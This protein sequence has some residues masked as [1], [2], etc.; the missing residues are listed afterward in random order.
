LAG[1]EEAVFAC[2][3]R[4]EGGLEDLLALA[5]AFSPSVE[6][7]DQQTVVFSI[8]GLG[9][10]IGGPDQIASEVARRGAEAG[11]TANLAIAADPDTAI[12]TARCLPGVH[13][14]PPGKEAFWLGRIP[15]SRVPMPEELHETLTRWGLR[16]LED[17]AALPPIGLAERLGE[18]GVRLYRTAT[19]AHTRPLK[20]APPEASYGENLELEDPV[21]NL[22]PLLFLI[23]RILNELCRRLAAQFQAANRVTTELTLEDGATHRRILE[24]PAPLADARQLL[25]LIQLDLEAHPP[26]AAVTAV[27][28]HLQPVRPRS[29]QNDLFLPP[30]PAP[31][32]LQLTL[33]RLEGIAG[34]GNVGSPEVLDTHRPDAVVMR[35]FHPPEGPSAKT[36]PAAPPPAPVVL[37]FYRPP[38][39]A[40]VRTRE[41]TPHS[42]RANGIRGE[43]TDAAGPWRTS[44]DWWTGA[45]WARDEWDLSLTDGG[46]YRVFLTLDAGAWFVQ[47]VYD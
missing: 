32:K 2:L 37:R 13:C 34:R 1:E 14:I 29:I 16:N 21:S 17:V 40:E 28:L 46:V 9:R 12:L 22:E 42:L 30:A 11:I 6:I 8:A 5:R 7:T 39:P 31:D 3:H 18:D 23:A 47:G 35:P 43:V 20:L 4:R 36:G 45:P 44:G 19:G 15:L 33:A 38:L 41:E 27:G 24:L 10:L 26:R 25:K